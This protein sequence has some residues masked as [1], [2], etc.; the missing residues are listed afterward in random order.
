MLCKAGPVVTSGVHTFY[1]NCL[2]CCLEC[3]SA[4]SNISSTCLEYLDDVDTD[5]CDPIYDCNAE[6]EAAVSACNMIDVV[7]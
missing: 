3:E 2:F 4:I 7:S 1:F 6:L 5:V